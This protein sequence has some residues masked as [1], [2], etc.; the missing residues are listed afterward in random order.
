MNA[1]FCVIEVLARVDFSL[2][3]YDSTTRSSRLLSHKYI[4]IRKYLSCS[5]YNKCS[6]SK[7]LML[8]AVG[9]IGDRVSA[10]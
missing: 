5:I 2:A 1:Q 7:S 4:D 8:F 3:E 6:I 10:L 9:G